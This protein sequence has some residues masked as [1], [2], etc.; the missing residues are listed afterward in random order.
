MQ[1]STALR[2]SGVSDKM[3]TQA[4]RALSILADL[5]AGTVK[6]VRLGLEPISVGVGKLIESVAGAVDKLGDST[7]PLKL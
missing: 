1:A 4:E 5:P 2:G 7:A 6:Q 3:A